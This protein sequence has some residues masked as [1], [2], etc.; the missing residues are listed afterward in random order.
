MPNV[1][2]IINVSYHNPQE[3]LWAEASICSSIF[4]RTRDV[5]ETAQVSST[6]TSA[7]EWCDFI[8]LLKEKAVKIIFTEH[9]NYCKVYNRL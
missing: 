3:I 1:K 7:T 8:V 9:I 6:A 4:L 2:F 5:V